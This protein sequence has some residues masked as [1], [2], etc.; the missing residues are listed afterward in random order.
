[1]PRGQI[2]GEDEQQPIR[3]WPGHA[4]AGHGG[5]VAGDNIADRVQHL[6]F[7][8]KR[9]VNPGGNTTSCRSVRP[10]SHAILGSDGSPV[11]VA[12]AMPTPA[13][14]SSASPTV[15]PTRR[16]GVEVVGPTAVMR[17]SEPGLEVRGDPVHAR[18]R[19]RAVARPLLGGP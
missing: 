10:E 13:H 7:G 5:A 19:A 12:Y 17:A 18:D 6:C 15:G 4:P 1:M 9:A 11:R 8:V 16:D 2:L 3:R 14:A